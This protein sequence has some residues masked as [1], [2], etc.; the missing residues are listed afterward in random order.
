MPPNADF[1]SSIVVDWA[2]DDDELPA[3]GDSAELGKILTDEDIDFQELRE[4]GATAAP[5]DKLG[6]WPA[7]LGSPAPPRCPECRKPMSYFLQI[8][9]KGLCG[10]AFGGQDDLARG[11][12][13]Q[14]AAHP[15]YV[16]F[17]WAGAGGPPQAR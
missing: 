13:F 17:R 14:C 9:S 8:E 3:F 2:E 12:L 15:E 1:T 5:G 4:L 6:G 7:W 10:H 11:H 16:A